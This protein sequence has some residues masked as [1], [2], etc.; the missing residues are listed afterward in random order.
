MRE[1][2]SRNLES[3]DLRNTCE[4]NF[5]KILLYDKKTTR[6]EEFVK[7]AINTNIKQDNFL[8]VFLFAQDVC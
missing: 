5:S 4:L 2:G 8:V 3:I 7:V 1:V 6:D